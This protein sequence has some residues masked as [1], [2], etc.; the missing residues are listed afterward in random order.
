MSTSHYLLGEVIRPIGLLVLKF[1]YS[2]KTICKI[3]RMIRGHIVSVQ[4][5]NNYNQLN[6]K[7]NMESGLILDLSYCTITKLLITIVSLSQCIIYKYVFI[8]FSL[9]FCA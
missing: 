4:S 9:L 1:V 5:P 3:I 8:W 6:G 7:W 2:Q